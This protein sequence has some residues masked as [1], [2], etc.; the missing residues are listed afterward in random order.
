MEASAVEKD[1]A[2]A[3]LSKARKH[4]AATERNF[5]EAVTSTVA[6][7]IA[8]F[9]AAVTSVPV[10]TSVTAG[11]GVAL[12]LVAAKDAADGAIHGAKALYQLA[13]GKS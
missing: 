2:T 12:L 6:G 11:I 10:L 13:Q 9:G 4:A 5:R 7:G 8:L 3:R 1:P